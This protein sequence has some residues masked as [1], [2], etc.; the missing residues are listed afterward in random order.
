[1]K[2]KELF[3]IDAVIT[4]GELTGIFG[5]GIFEEDECYGGIIVYHS[6][7][8]GWNLALK[9][10][11][12]KLDMDWLYIYYDHLSWWESDMFDGELENLF[13]SKFIENESDFTH[14]YYS[15]LFSKYQKED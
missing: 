1:M 14:A 13:V 5:R 6:G 10:T 2:F 8:N 7:T 3:P 12:D 9:T 11:C 15:W 4:T